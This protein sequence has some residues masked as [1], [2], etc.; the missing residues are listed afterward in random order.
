[1][2]TTA[3]DSDAAPVFFS[4]SSSLASSFK[5]PL[6]PRW[7]SQ[8]ATACR[9]EKP[10]ARSLAAHRESGEEKRALVSWV[11][12]RGEGVVGHYGLGVFCSHAPNTTPSS[13]SPNKCL[14]CGKEGRVRAATP[15][16]NRTKRPA[17]RGFR[18]KQ[19]SQSER[20]VGILRMSIQK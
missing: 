9:K 20:R 12:K 6:F 10:E 16:L 17:A 2:P 5:T 19:P 11:V 7:E 3:T 13:A 8:K 4:S 1:M 15:P 18:N 14:A